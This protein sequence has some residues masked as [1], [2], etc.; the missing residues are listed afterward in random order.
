MPAWFVQLPS[1]RYMLTAVAISENIEQVSS[2]Y[3]PGTYISWLL[4]TISALV[5]L[6]LDGKGQWIPSYGVVVSFLVYSGFATT[7]AAILFARA[8]PTLKSPAARHSLV[9]DCSWNSAMAI[10]RHTLTIYNLWGVIGFGNLKDQGYGYVNGVAHSSCI[11]LALASSLAPILASISTNISVST[12]FSGILT[13]ST[14]L[15]LS[16]LFLIWRVATIFAHYTRPPISS[17]TRNERILVEVGCFLQSLMATFI[18]LDVWLLSI[19]VPNTTPKVQPFL[20]ATIFPIPLCGCYAW[21]LPNGSDRRGR[22]LG[23]IGSLIIGLVVATIIHGTRAPGLEKELPSW[24]VKTNSH[25][26]DLD[27]L[28]TLLTGI[29]ISLGDIALPAIRW[30]KALI[31]LSEDSQ[32]TDT[33]HW[34]TRSGSRAV[35]RGENFRRYWNYFLSS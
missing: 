21:R 32:Y 28:A 11:R 1:N 7:H 15:L 8:V 24:T 30:L 20:D 12:N 16:S 35:H 25:I 34:G 17:M 26:T 22:G 33:T 31:R 6:W 19:Q 29:V 5:R 27:Q 9:M 10:I 14:S 2:L 18:I 23:V 13:A 3:G 4:V